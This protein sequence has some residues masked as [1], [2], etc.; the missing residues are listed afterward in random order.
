MS[1]YFLKDYSPSYIKNANSYMIWY[2]LAFPLNLMTERVVITSKGKKA[3]F[4][5]DINL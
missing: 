5:E 2:I 4:G 3:S 1:S